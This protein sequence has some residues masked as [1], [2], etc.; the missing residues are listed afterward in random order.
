MR[1]TD[2]QRSVWAVVGSGASRSIK[3][4]RWCSS[5]AC[6]DSRPWATSAAAG[7]VAH[8]GRQVGEVHP[9]ELLPVDVHED[10]LGLPD[11]G[12]ARS[13]GAGHSALEVRRLL[14]ALE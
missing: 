4:C 13:G 3:A 12:P 11:Q 10:V 5:G 8:P 7:V 14:G 6:A 9:R 2:D 1:Y